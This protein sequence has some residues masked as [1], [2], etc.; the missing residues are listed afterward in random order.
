[1]ASL[2]FVHATSLVCLALYVLSPRCRARRGRAQPSHML[3]SHAGRSGSSLAWPW[4]GCGLVVAS[5]CA[6]ALHP[7]SHGALLP[8]CRC[9]CSTTTLSYCHIAVVTVPYDSAPLS[10]VLDATAAVARTTV[11]AQGC[12]LH[13]FSIY[14]TMAAW[15]VPVED[16]RVLSIAPVPVSPRSRQPRSAKARSNRAPT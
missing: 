7:A 13:H 8:C 12:A 16:T 2:K 4:L 1:M 5:H 15:A 6:A 11:Q 14:G 9:C 10:A 3:W